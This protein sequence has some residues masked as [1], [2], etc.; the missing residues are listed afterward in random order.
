L[1]FPVLASRDWAMDGGGDT[2]D[3][4]G[5]KKPSGQAEPIRL[6]QR[7][8][9]ILEVRKA[10]KSRASGRQS[11]F[12]GS[13]QMQISCIRNTTKLVLF[14]VTSVTAAEDLTVLISD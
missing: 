10:E 9:S 11:Q 6:Q 14:C 2:R 8:I 13:F 4:R 1:G 5:G 12:D 3:R 7:Q